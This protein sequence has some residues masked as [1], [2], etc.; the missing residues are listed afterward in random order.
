MLSHC[1]TNRLLCKAKSIPCTLRKM[2]ISFILFSHCSNEQEINKFSF[3]VNVNTGR[4]TWFC[5]PTYHPGLRH[6]SSQVLPPSLVDL[7]DECSLC[8]KKK[9]LSKVILSVTL[10]ELTLKCN[11][12]VKQ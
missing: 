3:G 6:I 1:L 9:M 12:L 2:G 11:N 4:L 10:D 8:E 7:S 5:N